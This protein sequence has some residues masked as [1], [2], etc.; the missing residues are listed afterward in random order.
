MNI[1]DLVRAPILLVLGFMQRD[2]CATLAPHLLAAALS[3][4]T[5]ETRSRELGRIFRCLPSPL[6]IAMCKEC[7]QFEFHH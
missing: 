5:G 6:V 7:S 1:C 4:Y 3:S 2:G